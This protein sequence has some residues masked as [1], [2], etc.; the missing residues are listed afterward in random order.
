MK[1]VRIPR[2][3][4]LPELA[5]FQF[6]NC[7]EVTTIESDEYGGLSKIRFSEQ[8]RSDRQKRP[9]KKSAGASFREGRYLSTRDSWI[10]QQ[11]QWIPDTLAA[12][13]FTRAFWQSD[14]S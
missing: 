13:A 2:I 10:L 1:L 8:F 7:E 14:S 3:G 9:H 4:G 6:P 12:V 11:H 5:T